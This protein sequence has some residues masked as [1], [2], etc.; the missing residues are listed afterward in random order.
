AQSAL[1]GATAGT[2]QNKRLDEQLHATKYREH[3]D[4]QDNWLGKRH[5]NIPELAEGTRTVDR[6]R[7]V[8]VTRNVRQSGREVDDIDSGPPPHRHDDHRWDGQIS[9]FQ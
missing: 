8:H 3:G 6:S 1:P 2:P 5:G 7:L 4:E 9:G